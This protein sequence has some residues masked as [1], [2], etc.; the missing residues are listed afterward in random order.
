MLD[1]AHARFNIIPFNSVDI[2]R[3]LH[4]LLQISLGRIL[5]YKTAKVSRTV[6]HKRQQ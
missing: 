6:L 4:K 3:K 1:T 2:I 5:F